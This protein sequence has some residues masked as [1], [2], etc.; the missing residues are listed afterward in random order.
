MDVPADTDSDSA[1]EQNDV[2]KT[3]LEPEASTSD[4]V[5][6]VLSQVQTEFTEWNVAH[7]HQVLTSFTAPSTWRSR[8]HPDLPIPNPSPDAR[9]ALQVADFPSPLVTQEVYA[10]DGAVIE[11]SSVKSDI[12]Y[13]TS[14]LEPHPPYESCSPL[15]RSVFHGDDSDNMNF[16]PYADDN[17]FDQDNHTFHYGSFSWQDTFDPDLEV[18]VLEAVYRL[19]IQHALTYDD[20]EGCNVLPLKLRSRSGIPGLLSIARRR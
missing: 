3:L 4:L 19:L 14:S 15:H 16:I 18:I 5:Q 9:P 7:C 8:L 13:L 10:S 20:I 2:L 1:D 17:T 6:S 12:I 11:I